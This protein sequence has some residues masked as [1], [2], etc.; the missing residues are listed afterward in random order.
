M[1]V[2]SVIV[3]RKKRPDLERPY[4][5]WGYP[6]TPVLFVLAAIYVAISALIGQFRNAMGGLLIIIIGIPAYFFWRTDRRG[7]KLSM[8]GIGLA[9]AAAFARY[10]L[11]ATSGE[12]IRWAALC[13]GAVGI[14]MIFLGLAMASKDRKE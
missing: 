3:L 9:L 7:I 13:V 14:I 4:K 2:A 11:L 6:V 5:T 10:F 8:V 1:T 12:V